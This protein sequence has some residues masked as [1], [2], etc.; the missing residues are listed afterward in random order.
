M[1]CGEALKNPYTLHLKSCQL[2]EVLFTLCGV[3]PLWCVVVGFL[4]CLPSSDEIEGGGAYVAITTII[5]I[6][7]LC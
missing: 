7:H 6:F 3:P 2:H 1:L 5:A 4:S